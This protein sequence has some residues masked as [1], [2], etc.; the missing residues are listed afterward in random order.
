MKKICLF[1]VSTMLLLAVHSQDIKLG[2]KLGANLSDASGNSF[3]S[4]YNFGY[5]VGLFTELM[6]TKKYGI[7]PELLFSESNLRPA[8]EFTDLY[9]TINLQT[10]TGLR[11]IKL[12]YLSIPVLFTYKPVPIIALQVGPQFGILMNQTKSLRGNATDAFKDGDLSI[13]AGAQ[14][15]ILKFRVYGRYAIGTRNLNL[16][17]LQTWKSQNLQLGIGVTF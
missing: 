7:Q 16:Q 8:D 9:N 4:G 10:V 6:A 12:Q 17:D 1:L 2:F 14:V 3:K 15:T 11:K 5:Q 13:V